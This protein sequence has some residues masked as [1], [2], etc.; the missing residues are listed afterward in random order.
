MGSLEHVTLISRLKGIFTP[1]MRKHF[2]SGERV[3]VSAKGG[4]SSD[5]HGV[6]SG[7]PDSVNTRQGEDF[8]YWVRFDTP[9]HDLS[10][11]GPYEEAHILSRYLTYVS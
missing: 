8:F 4:W 5:F 9:Q 3:S 2:E 6:I 10:E 1:G 7:G 11:D